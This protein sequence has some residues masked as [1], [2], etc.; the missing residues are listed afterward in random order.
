VNDSNTIKVVLAECHN[1]VREAFRSLLQTI[2]GFDMVGEASGAQDVIDLVSTH[3]PDVVLLMIDGAAESELELLQRLSDIAEQTSVL[4]VT[5]QQDPALHAR[6]IE[7]GAMGVVMKDQSAKV[8]VKALRKVCAGEIWLDHVRATGV[9]NR[10]TRRHVDDDPEVAKVVSLTPR[11]R[12]I[13]ALITEG[14][15]N[16]E[17]ADRL[18]ISEATARNHLTSILDKL[19]LVDRFQLTVY[20]FR[21]G[22]VLCPQTPAMLR[23]AATMTSS[24]HQRGDAA[25]GAS[26]SRRRQ[27]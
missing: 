21:R 14:L 22:L 2:G 9:L 18:F 15:T 24:A 17:V 27:A 11:E 19:D 5:G 7:L 13:V 4:V 20:A 26:S 23:V 3:R 8:L 6:A 25:S 1:L 12:Q 16:K 10:L